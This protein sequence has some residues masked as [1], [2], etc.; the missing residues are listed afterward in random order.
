MPLRVEQDCPQCGSP[1][2]MDETHRLLRCSYCTVQSFLNNTGPLHFIL[3][4][5]EPDPYTIYAPYIRFKG[6]IY[7]CLTDRIEHRVADI[8]ARGVELPFLPPSLGLRPQAMKMRFADPSLPGSF[9]Q[10]SVTA[11]KILARAV[12]NPKIRDEKILHQTYIGDMLNTIYLPLSIRDEEI[13]DGVLERPLAKIPEDAMPFEAA[14]IDNSA[15]KPLFLPALCPQCGWNLEGEADSVV[16][17]CSNCNTGWQAGGSGFAEVRIQTTPATGEKEL[18]IP[19]W[20]FKIGTNGA[21]LNSFADFI[22][23]T[24]QAL[25]VK[26]EWEEM[27]L[28]F[29]CPAFKVRPQDFLR[30]STQMSV[31]QRHLLQTTESI[32]AKNLFPVTL[33]HS[34][35]KRSLKVILANSAVSRSRVFPLLPE[36]DFE[37]KE[38]FLHYLP[39]EKTSHEMYQKELDVI[40]NQRALTYGRTL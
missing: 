12:K 4:R 15:W 29:V 19:F 6:T 31:S 8:S 14:E 20:N 24:N 21:R 33:T 1:F 18:F 17:L 7:N 10:K 32:P 25:I 38:Y 11:D 5:R 34:D 40:I 3:P 36:I 13:L 27:E 30:L 22:H 23:L 39:F 9:L 2:E 37:V 28:Y 35:V 26:P 16:L